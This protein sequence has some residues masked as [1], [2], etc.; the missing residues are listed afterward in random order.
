MAVN[1]DWPRRLPGG[2]A[3]LIHNMRFLFVGFAVILGGMALLLAMFWFHMSTMAQV[4]GLTEGPSPKTRAAI[5]M[6][7]AAESRTFGLFTLIA[8]PDVFDRIELRESLSGQASAF[9]AA[10]ER[11]AD[12]EMTRAEEA[13]LNRLLDHAKASQPV[14]DGALSMA[15]RAGW[16]PDLRPR[17]LAAITA[18]RNV[19]EAA[20]T[21]VRTVRNATR[22]RRAT[23]EARKATESRTI[24]VLGATVFLV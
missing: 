24:A 8:T 13:A 14:I 6:R 17:M 21:F 23:L 18:F 20:D 7:D 19:Q 1:A 4:S 22:E 12:I 5:R 11:L 10:R 3:G 9:I 15:E 2:E 16:S